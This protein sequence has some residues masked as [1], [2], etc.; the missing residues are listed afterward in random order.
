MGKN[1]QNQG[2]EKNTGYALRLA[3]I[4]ALNKER[5]R[6]KRSI[7]SLAEDV[8]WDTP[9]MSRYLNGKGGTDSLE[10]YFEVAMALGLRPGEK[11][12]EIMDGTS[13]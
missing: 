12:N 8:G 6:Q 5:K 3:A 13:D 2:S 7:T 10:N 4:E 1:K 11:L 9:K